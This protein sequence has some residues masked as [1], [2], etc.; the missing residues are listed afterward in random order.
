MVFNPFT[1]NYDDVYILP[2]FILNVSDEEQ[3][4]KVDILGDKVNKSHLL[5]SSN[6]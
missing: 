2:R 3:Y 1:R 4:W 5:G 6:F